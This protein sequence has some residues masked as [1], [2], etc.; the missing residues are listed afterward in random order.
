MSYFEAVR[1][2]VNSRPLPYK[3]PQ[4]HLSG[5]T[6]YAVSAVSVKTW[7][8]RA[9]KLTVFCTYVAF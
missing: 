7:D 5:L 4:D 2:Q 1:R 8:L 3:R 9:H 6:F